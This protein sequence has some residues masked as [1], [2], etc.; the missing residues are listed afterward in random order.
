MRTAAISQTANKMSPYASINVAA[1]LTGDD[2]VPTMHGARREIAAFA[3]SLTGR[4]RRHAP[5]SGNT[6]RS[7]I[8]RT[9]QAAYDEIATV[10]NEMGEL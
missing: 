10:L 7:E 8:I 4:N 9:A 3:D 5:I 6:I 2:S 1:L